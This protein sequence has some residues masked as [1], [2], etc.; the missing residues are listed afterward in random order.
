MFLRVGGDYD[1]RGQ[2]AGEGL[3]PVR[4]WLC[5]QKCFVAYMLLVN[6]H[7]NLRTVLVYP[8]LSEKG[9]T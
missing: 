2:D 3:K 5:T 8:F 7:R 6:A 4:N 1:G 9:E